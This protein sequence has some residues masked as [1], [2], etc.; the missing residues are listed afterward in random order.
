M[1]FGATDHAKSAIRQFVHNGALREPPDPTPGQH[2]PLDGFGQRIY[3]A[4]PQR[5]FARSDGL[6]LD[7]AEKTGRVISK[8]GNA[9]AVLVRRVPTFPGGGLG[10]GDRLQHVGA[11]A[12][13]GETM[14]L[15]LRH[16]IAVAI[17]MQEVTQ[18]FGK[19]LT[20]RARVP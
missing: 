18:T 14:F 1:P 9:S 16:H 19:Q 12:L 15:E 13:T 5:W 20:A 8:M 2:T 17:V 6:I 11:N 10:L 4:H 7:G 3:V